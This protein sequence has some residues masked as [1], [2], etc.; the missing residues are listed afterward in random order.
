MELNKEVNKSLESSVLVGSISAPQTGAGPIIVAA[1][2]V[3]RGIREIAHYTVLHDSGEFELMVDK[4]EYYVVAYRDRN[5]NLVLESGEPAEKYG[6]LISAPAGG[7]VPPI[8]F[9]IPAT[10]KV[11]DLPLPF[12]I[13]RDRPKKLYSRQAG[14]KLDLDD[15]LFS[16]ENGQK[17]YWEPVKFYKEIGGN[18]YFL[19]DYDPKK[20]PVLFIHGATGTPGGWKYFVDHIDRTHFQPWFFYYPS[21]ARIQSM[22]YLLFW[23]LH[24]L[25][26][27]YGFSKMCITAHSMGGLIAKSFINDYGK[28]C[29]YV[30]LFISLATPWGGDKM[31]EYGVKQSPAVIPCWIDMQPESEFFK[32]LYNTKMPEDMTFYMFYG[33]K[34][35]RNIFQSNNDGTITLASLLNGKLQSAAQKIFAFNEDHASIASS[36]EVMSQYNMLVNAFDEKNSISPK[37][38]GGYL[39]IHLSKINLSEGERLQPTFVLHP[40]DEDHEDTILYLKD[41]EADQ[42]LGPFTTGKYSASIVATGAKSDKTYAPILIENNKTN[43]V[44]FILTPDGIIS[45]YVTTALKPEDR[46]VGMPA[47]KYLPLDKKI[48]IQSVTLRGSGIKRILHPI[49][50]ENVKF[51]NLVISHNDFCYNEHY[52]FFGLP[53]GDYEL[54]IKA[55][56]YQSI[57]KKFRIKPGHQEDFSVT[58]LIPEM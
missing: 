38:F 3:N 43:E 19:E 18:I 8:H 14:T 55:Q 48:I 34:G 53:A 25:Q 45:G 46:P 57:V 12:E 21:G 29:P 42:M 11:S 23:K 6:K 15:E 36:K 30:K 31:A 39:R 20:I 33:Y 24:T 41:D 27:K 52:F 47:D 2:S 22:S 26:I 44:T 51:S 1:Y 4:G 7:V 35:N 17:G 49:E 10:G 28:Y 40:L 32:S 13:S 54:V 9:T 5:S 56:S 16:D 50:D 37:H 58:E